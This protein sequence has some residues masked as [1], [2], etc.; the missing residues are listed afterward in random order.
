MADVRLSAAISQKSLTN[1]RKDLRNAISGIDIQIS[2]KS[3]QRQGDRLK[4]QFNLAYPFRLNQNDVKRERGRLRRNLGNLNIDFKF[5]DEVRK[6]RRQL[7]NIR[8]KPQLSQ[9]T[10]KEIQSLKIKPSFKFTKAEGN[11]L[12]EQMN[13]FFRANPVTI[14]T[15]P[16]KRSLG[17]TRQTARA[18]TGAAAAGA[19]AAGG[20]FVPPSVD[21]TKQ[22]VAKA[23]QQHQKLQKQ[24]QDSTKQTR[25]L[26]STVQNT[27]EELLTF[28]DRLGFTTN[29]LAAYVVP[30][31]AFIQIAQGIQ[32]AKESI[33]EINK[34]TKQLTQILGNNEDVANRVAD[35]VTQIGTR[36]GVAADELLRTTVT[37]AQAGSK[38]RDAEALVDT[39]SNL[40][41][42]DLA[43]TFGNIED[44]S[45]GVIASLNQFNLEGKESI[46]V[47]DT[48]N[49]LAKQF[50]VA[51]EDIFTA[52]RRGGGSFSATGGTIEEFGALV[53]ALRQITGREASSIGTGIKTI[54]ARLFRQEN[55]KRLENLGA[56]IRTDTGEIKDITN[57][58]L[59][60]GRVTQDLGRQ[61]RINLI[62]DLVGFR[63]SGM[64]LS[65]IQNFETFKDAIEEARDSAGSLNRDAATGLE[66]ID[67]QLQ[68]IASRFQEVFQDIARDQGFQSLVNQF[69][70]LAKTAAN[71]LDAVQPF[72]PVL[73][74]L[75]ALKL[76]VGI[77]RGAG[78]FVRG[79]N[80]F[81][82]GR[83]QDAA[84]RHGSLGG[85]FDNVA[86]STRDPKTRAVLENTAALREN[87]MAERGETRGLSRSQRR[88][89]TFNR[90]ADRQQQ[91]LRTRRNARVSGLAQANMVMG[92]TGRPITNLRG[93]LTNNQAALDQLR[94]ERSRVQSEISRFSRGKRVPSNFLRTQRRTL[95]LNRRLGGDAPDPGPLGRA[96]M[97]EQNRSELPGLRSRLSGL[98]LAIQNRTD[99]LNKL[100]AIGSRLAKA[101]VEL[102]KATNNRARRFR[103][104]ARTIR[105]QAGFTS[106]IRGT[107]KA[108]GLN[109]AR[110]GGLGLA[111]GVGGRALGGLRR[112]A[113]RLIGNEIGAQLV[114]A[115]GS[116]IVVDQIL[117]E[118][119]TRGL[120][121][122]EGDL[123]SNLLKRIRRERR[124][125][126]RSDDA[127]AASTGALIGSVIGTSIA[128][129]LGTLLGGLAGGGI[130]F[131]ASRA[132]QLLTDAGGIDASKK[133]FRAISRQGKLKDF[134]SGTA[135]L[136]G[137]IQTESVLGALNSTSGEAFAQQLAAQRRRRATSLI[138]GG[139]NA[140]VAGEKASAQITNKIAT[141]LAET[142]DEFNFKQAKNRIDQLLKTV[143]ARFT[144]LF[145]IDAKKLASINKSIDSGVDA[146]LKFSRRFDK[147]TTKLEEAAFRLSGAG[148]ALTNFSDIVTSGNLTNL[149]AKGIGTSVSRQLNLFTRNIGADDRFKTQA[150]VGQLFGGVLD[151]DTQKVISEGQLLRGG[152]RNLGTGIAGVVQGALSNNNVTTLRGEAGKEARQAAKERASILRDELVERLDR[153]A[154][155]PEVRQQVD[156]L[157]RTDITELVDLQNFAENPEKAAQSLVESFDTLEDKAIKKLQ[158]TVEKFNAELSKSNALFKAQQ[159][160]LD[161]INSLQNKQSNIRLNR[162]GRFEG[163]GLTTEDRINFLQNRI[164]GISGR[165]NPITGERINEFNQN[166]SRLRTIRNQLRNQNLTPQEELNRRREANELQQSTNEFRRRF[167][168]NEETR[169]QLLSANNKLLSALNDTIDRRVDAIRNVGSMSFSDRRQLEL[170]RNRVQDVFGGT[171]GRLRGGNGDI[172]TIDRLLNNPERLRELIGGFED[173]LGNPRNVKAIQSLIQSG[174]LPFGKSGAPSARVG[175]VLQFLQG[176][177]SD[178]TGDTT[179]KELEK[180]AKQRAK[181]RDRAGSIEQQQLDVLKSIESNIRKAIPKQRDL[182]DRNN[183][184]PV[185]DLQ[186]I[187]ND[188]RDF[189]K[190]VKLE[191]QKSKSAFEQLFEAIKNAQNPR[192]E[193]ELDLNVSGFSNL[194]NASDKEIKVLI[195]MIK[196]LIQVLKSKSSNKQSG[197]LRNALQQ[198]LSELQAQL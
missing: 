76:G 113:G 30:A 165:I 56:N 50:A 186:G 128:P 97:F 68:S 142:S 32:F 191:N 6:I 80:V 190:D 172:P 60:L 118:I 140:E 55:V 149:D 105:G 69:T 123:R 96:A 59:E 138:A 89:N 184:T 28:S 168:R 13:A 23:A 98:N 106:F 163:A 21:Q 87:T 119:Q 102:R 35:S 58:L 77:F 148:D 46:R 72:L 169:N 176:L 14:T 173:N 115:I 40:A 124:S 52:V 164:S 136:V 4:K 47:L 33:I 37:V 64:I 110:E 183:P 16:D 11:R 166:N 170:R 122:D 189:V 150:K 167:Q 17:A 180:L 81:S 139:T 51:S 195:A 130:G 133:A 1:M 197:E 156:R 20:A 154:F 174:A 62:E 67:K 116:Q 198:V 108:I 120:V 19:T 111:R 103:R 161:K 79:A 129:G 147:E 155:S 145:D 187:L 162:L 61:E 39:V 36:F 29:R 193:G 54:S 185:A 44:T 144:D 151:R 104:E 63:R 10:K 93:V 179:L 9:Q 83:L 31:S 7:N 178:L 18:T 26:R 78:N 134:S 107:R 75:G 70:T 160:S 42:S 38:F 27:S 73:A 90:L 114:G 146:L 177:S 188:I 15:K 192:F 92:Q 112:G 65:F 71:A 101:D 131:T 152:L 74:Q 158:K 41:K 157:R 141:R 99:R 91:A 5:Q 181:A 196:K 66:R 137:Q 24:T 3:I 82:P 132:N 143:Q 125:S 126:I 194:E 175:R 117:P 94:Q 8:F 45:R 127:S 88:Q 53:A 22:R 12:R 34:S 2:R 121:N 135:A 95:E 25:N 109:R 48:A 49:Q 84:R 153:N 182:G 86:A 171:L 100:S 159:A 57:V 43:A 85:D